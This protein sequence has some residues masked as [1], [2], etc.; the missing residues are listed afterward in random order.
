MLKRHP[1]IECNQMLPYQI[2]EYEPRQNN[3]EFDSTKEVLVE[4][5]QEMVEKRQFESIYKAIETITETK[6]EDF[7]KIKR[8]LFL[9]SNILKQIKSLIL[10]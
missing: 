7:L 1:P 10:F 2:N 4:A 3:I 6:Y 9:D 8:Y 5:D